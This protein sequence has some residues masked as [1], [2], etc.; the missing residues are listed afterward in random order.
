MPETPP[1]PPA[2]LCVCPPHNKSLP[3][4]PR[5]LSAT[6]HLLDLPP[7]ALQHVLG[8]CSEP[9]R[10]VGAHQCGGALGAGATG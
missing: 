10:P 1:L 7:D 4:V 6:A 8:M 9:E 2:F 5:P 3:C